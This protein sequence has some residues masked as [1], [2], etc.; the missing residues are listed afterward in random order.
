MSTQMISLSLAKSIAEIMSEFDWEKF[1]E[2]E[3]INTEVEQYDIKDQVIDYLFEA[4]LKKVD[5]EASHHLVYNYYKSDD[6]GDEFLTLSY[7]PIIAG[8]H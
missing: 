6:N 3:S 4:A 7:S 2:L 5:I 1:F 8:E